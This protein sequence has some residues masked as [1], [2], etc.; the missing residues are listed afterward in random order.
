MSPLRLTIGTC[1]PTMNASSVGGTTRTRLTGRYVANRFRCA[2]R[3]A[4]SCS[5]RDGQQ[6]GS[7]IDR[8]ISM[9]RFCATYNSSISRC[10]VMRYLCCT[11]PKPEFSE[12]TRSIEL[13]M[14]VLRGL[15]FFCRDF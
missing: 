4:L 15:A 8:N 5:V 10:A 11:D 3:A 6:S 7:R 13:M 14:A 2:V 1:H 12:E 9:T